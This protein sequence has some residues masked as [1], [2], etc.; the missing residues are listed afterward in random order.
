MGSA[1]RIAAGAARK[2]GVRR[3]GF[4]GGAIRT[5]PGSC[6]RGGLVPTGARKGRASFLVMAFEPVRILTMGDQLTT[7]GHH[8]ELALR[9]PSL[10]AGTYVGATAVNPI[11]GKSPLSPRCVHH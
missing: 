1:T 11:C 8:R 2:R 10:F 6:F 7:C 5:A 9:H 3:R 4:L